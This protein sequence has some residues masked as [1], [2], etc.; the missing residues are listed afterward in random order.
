MDKIKKHTYHY[1]YV[2]AAACFGIQA[3]GVGTYVTYGVFFNSLASEF[4]WSRAAISGASSIAFF[5]MGLF[6]IFVGRLNDKIGPRNVMAV[7]GFLFGLGHLLMSGLGAVWQLYLF[8]GVI[9]GIGLSSVDVI[10]LST[11]ARWFF[12]KRGIMTGI[13]K[14]GTGAGQFI[15][16][17][18][19]SMLITSYGWRTSYIIIGVGVLI[20]L[21]AIAQFLRRD[22]S[23]I[24]PLPDCENNVS[25]SKPGLA[26]EGLSLGEAVRTRQ[27]WTICSV[28]LAIV[29]CFMSILV[30]IVPHAQDL[31]ISATRAASVLSAIGGVSM[32]GRFI[33]GIAIDRIGSKR[34]MILCFI[35]LIAGL[36]W[37]QMSKELWT[38][39]VFAAIYGIA[40]GGYFTTISPIVAEFFGLN[41]HG[42][43]FG[44][45]AFS[46]TIGG[47]IGP[48]L[49]GYIFDVTAGYVLAFW[50][51]TLMSASGLLLLLLLKQADAIRQK[52][53]GSDA[54]Q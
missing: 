41:A 24:S 23:Q 31:K 30:H 17:L 22:P 32:A 21:V 10:A 53:I 48:I 20:S 39:Y 4:G 37:L 35:L 11:T 38:L 43:L 6:G 36:L 54:T 25:V 47:A 29:F 7:T 19:V 44:I 26:A 12:R 27:F 28:N 1:G 14:V 34:A 16:P 52:N 33:T 42:V 3:I 2:I 13:V 9:I 50:L 15:M 49:A 45:V 8:Y 51:C 18:V 46:G 5:L 40:H